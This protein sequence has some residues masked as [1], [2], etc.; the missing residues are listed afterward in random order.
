MPDVLR[1]IGNCADCCALPL[2]VAPNNLMV[3]MSLITRLVREPLLHFLLIGGIIFVAFAY[4][5]P[6]ESESDAD[7]SI[8]IT[9]QDLLQMVEQ[10]RTTWRRLPTETEVDILIDSKLREHVLVREAQSLSL[11][12]GDP[13]IRQRLSQKMNFLITSAAGAVAPTEDEL[14]AYFEENQKPFLL[15]RKLA[16]EQVFVGDAL[17]AAAFDDMLTELNSGADPQSFGRGSLIPEVFGLTDKTRVEAR[18]GAGTF[19]SLDALEPGVWAGPLKSGFG[20]HAVRITDAQGGAVPPLEEVRD[21]VL[22]AYRTAKAQEVTKE[23]LAELTANY[24]VNVP[25]ADA[26]KAVLQ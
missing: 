17:D 3:P 16:F 14:R 22:E 25:D 2:F 4:V 21:A 15:P 9:Q 11:D 7:N 13:V 5:N 10:F 26:R 1:H 18:L 23:I 19:D 12:Q 6:D 24:V 8:E 20:F